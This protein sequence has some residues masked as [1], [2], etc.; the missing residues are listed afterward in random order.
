MLEDHAD[1]AA[2]GTQI[3]GGKRGEIAPLD[4]HAAFARAR[5][6]VDRADQRAFAGPASPD[7]AEDFAGGNRQIDVMQRFDPAPRPGEAL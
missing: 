2:R 7:D 4:N 6:H 5:Q 1:A 3:G